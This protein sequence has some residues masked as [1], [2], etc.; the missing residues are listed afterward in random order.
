MALNATWTFSD[1]QVPLCANTTASDL[2]RSFLVQLKEFLVNSGGW[3]VESSALSGT[4][5]NSDLWGTSW[6]SLQ[7]HYQ[8]YTHS[9]ITLKSPEGIV[10]GAD[11]TGTGDQSRLW[12]VLD[13]AYPQGNGYAIFTLHLTAPTGGSVSTAPTSNTVVGYTSI[14]QFMYGSYSTRFHFGVTGKGFFRVLVSNAAVNMHTGLFLFPI[15]GVQATPVN[16]YA[17]ATGFKLISQSNGFQNMS[18]HNVF[19]SLHGW[20]NTGV[21]AY[22]YLDGHYLSNYNSNRLI[23]SSINNLG[24]IAGRLPSSDIFL[25]NSLGTHTFA[26]GKV[27]DFAITGALPANYT[28]CE[29]VAEHLTLQFAN[30]SLIIPVNATVFISG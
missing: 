30:G 19:N 28:A 8:G 24:D 2:E 9:W 29:S 26:I 25:Y 10:A 11:G 12:L 27:A 15:M 6:S 18:I 17:Y 16:D 20:T 5:S 13:F 23:G 3:S 4:T 1:N 14:T 21:S 22:Y 7:G